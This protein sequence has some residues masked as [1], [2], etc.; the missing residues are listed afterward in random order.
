M[1][2]KDEIREILEKWEKDISNIDMDRYPTSFAFL[3]GAIKAL[4][5]VLD[6]DKT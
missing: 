2:S 1:K 3:R 5:C 6:D 4:K